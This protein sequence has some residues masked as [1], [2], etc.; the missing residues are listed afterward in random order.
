MSEIAGCQHTWDVL[1][2]G[3]PSGTGKSSVSYP[4]ARHFDMG[5]T[6]VDDLFIALECLTTPEQQPEI[7]YWRTHPEAT[8]LPAEKILERQLALSRVMSPMITAVVNNHIETVMPI[9][10]DGDYILPEIIAPPNNKQLLDA[11][12]VQ[13]VFLYE[14]DEQQ[15]VKNF[16]QREPNEGTQTKRAQVSWLFGQWLKNECEQY[17]LIA[18]PARP[19]DTLIPRINEAI[20]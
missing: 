5:I 15:I 12:R 10:L 20:S 7:H 18:L 6:E 19:W 16:A 14:P 1:L 11:D 3:G 13:A 8:E 17:G 4:L 2:I 9:V